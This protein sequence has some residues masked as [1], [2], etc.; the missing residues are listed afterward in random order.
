MNTQHNPSD[1]GAA[2]YRQGA[3]ERL[4]DASHLLRMKAFAGSI[5]LAGRSVEGMLR[6]VVWQHDSEIRTG[7]KSLDTG[8]DLKRLLSEIGHLGLLRED[9]Q[10]NE[11]R[12]RVQMV[13]RL[14]FNNMRFAPSDRVEDY[15]KRLGD[16]TKRRTLKQAATDYYDAC[17]G[18]IKRCE[19]LL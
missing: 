15:W 8:H 11:F 1:F 13:A 12:K 9:S 18:V 5:Y 17:G 16:V 2:D 14:W 6:A 7:R 4:A 19:K 3:L 10:D